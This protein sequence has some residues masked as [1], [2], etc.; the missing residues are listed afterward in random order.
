MPP[1]TVNDGWVSAAGDEQ[2]LEQRVAGGVRRLVEVGQHGGDDV[3]LEARA[4]L[5]DQRRLDRRR[6]AVV[7]R[8]GHRERQVVEHPVLGGGVAE[9][10]EQRV[11]ELLAGRLAPQQLLDEEVAC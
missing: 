1:R 5:L 4:H 7:D 2:A 9:Q 11:G 6:A 3:L 10:V 8:A